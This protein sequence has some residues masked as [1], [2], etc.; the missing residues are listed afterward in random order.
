MKIIEF[1][2][3]FCLTCNLGSVTHPVEICEAAASA[4]EQAS[5]DGGGRGRGLRCR[6]GPR[7]DEETRRSFLA[8][9]ARSLD[10]DVRA[11]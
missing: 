8:H 5:R 6:V 3:S 2:E 9:L 11:T 7:G 1:K 10:R 4:R